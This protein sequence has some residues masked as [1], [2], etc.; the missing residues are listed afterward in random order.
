MVVFKKYN[1]DGERYLGG[2][3]I[4]GLGEINRQVMHL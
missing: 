2:N 1:N 4:E 3:T